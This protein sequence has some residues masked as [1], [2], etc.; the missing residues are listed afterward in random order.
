MIFV[1][2]TQG[3]AERTIELL[4]DYSVFAVPIERAEDAHTA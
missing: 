4:G 2:H 1:A 3:R